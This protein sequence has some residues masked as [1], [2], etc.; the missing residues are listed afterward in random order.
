MGSFTDKLN[1]LEATIKVLR[2][3]TE[4]SNDAGQRSPEWFAQR[5]GKFTGS[6]ISELMK[7]GRATAKK[8]WSEPEKIFDL[9]AG[10]LSY[11]YAKA[12]ERQRNKVVESATTASMRYGT[13]NETVLKDLYMSENI[14]LRF[15][16]VG[17]LEFIKGIAGAS[18]DGRIFSDKEVYGVEFKCATTWEQF[19]NRTEIEITP[20]HMDFWQ[21][22]AE[23]LAMVVDK[24]IY[25]V[26]E[27][28]ESIFEPN[29]THY[30]KKIVYTSELHQAAIIKRCEF[31]D[32]IIKEY[33]KGKNNFPKCV[34]IASLT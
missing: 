10:A 13:E 29:I 7:C 14:D 34:Q 2:S 20:S 22:Q 4:Q 31:G 23:M 9:G 28:S 1:D 30:S 12:K 17:F 3:E 6:K 25:I 24:M 21:L 18:G 15:E 16:E 26:A 8:A 33:L 5:L 27:P 19:Y 11:I 32:K